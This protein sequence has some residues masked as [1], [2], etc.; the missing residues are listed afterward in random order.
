[1]EDPILILHALDAAPDPGQCIR[2]SHLAE[3]RNLYEAKIH[4][5]TLVDVVEAQCLPRVTRAA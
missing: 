2:Q 4:F 5:S 3:A 1:V